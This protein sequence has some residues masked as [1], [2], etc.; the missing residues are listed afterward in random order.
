MTAAGPPSFGFSSMQMLAWQTVDNRCATTSTVRLMEAVLIASCTLYSVSASRAEVPSSNTSMGGWH[1]RALAIAM[2][3]FWP[4]ET[5][6]FWASPM[7]V[8]N[9]CGKLEL[10][11]SSQTCASRN[12]CS[13]SASLALRLPYL[14]FSK[15]VVLK[16]SGSWLTMPI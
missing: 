11:N 5:W 14:M 10:F 8:S 13:T 1:R 3:C 2:R 7:V 9:L 15:M 12:A 16:S 6:I 4:A